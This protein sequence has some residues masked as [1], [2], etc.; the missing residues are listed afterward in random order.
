MGYR[1]H[2]YPVS[3]LVDTEAPSRWEKVHGDQTV[4][5]TEAAAVLRTGLKDMG[6]SRP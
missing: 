4:A 1:Q 2:S 5:M 3:G 6:P